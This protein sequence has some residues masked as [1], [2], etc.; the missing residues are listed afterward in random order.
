VAIRAVSEGLSLGR[1]A[2]AGL[3]A[4]L[5]L[6]AAAAALAEPLRQPMPAELVGSR[7]VVAMRGTTPSPELVERVRR[8]QLSGVILFARNVVDSEQLRALTGTL[9]RAARAGGRPPLL[10]CVDQEGGSVRRVSWAP[11]A[12][13]AAELGSLPPAAVRREGR[14][15]GLALRA[16]GVNCDLAPVADVPSEGTFLGARAFSRDAA[17]AGSLAAAFARGLADARVLAAA[18]HFPGIGRAQVSTDRAAVRIGASRAALERD[19]GPF[20]AL[21]AEQVPLVMVSNASYT[22]FGPEPAAWSRRISSR[23]LRQ[24]LGFDG[25]T[26]TDSLDAPAAARGWETSRTAFLAARAGVDLLLVT[27]SEAT[28]RGVFTSLLR[29]AREG[30]LGRVGLERSHARI[31]ALRAGLP[32]G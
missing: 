12:R 18:K 7:L 28:S 8:G 15:T 21:V 25:V 32:R 10:V 3:A 17:T 27:G 5:V 4:A 29:A 20:R 16:G 23:L 30:L 24:E 2:A 31:T 26:M 19:L 1:A 9:Q 6:G 22:P 11:P 14:I 13:S